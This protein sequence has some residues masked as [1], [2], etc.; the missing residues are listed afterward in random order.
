MKESVGFYAQ[1]I[2]T[3]HFISHNYM[4]SVKE[5]ICADRKRGQL[6]LYFA[7]WKLLS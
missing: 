7:K 5:L 3:I 2:I 1:K 6:Y 4:S